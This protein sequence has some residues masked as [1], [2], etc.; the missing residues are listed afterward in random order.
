MQLLT[1]DARKLM[2]NDG[3]QELE[4]CNWANPLPDTFLIIHLIYCTL[5]IKLFIMMNGFSSFFNQVF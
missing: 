5:I 2:G 3:N 4:I 1:M